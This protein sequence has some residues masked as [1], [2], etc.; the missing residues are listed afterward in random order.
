[1]HETVS[2]PLLRRA[3]AITGVKLRYRNHLEIINGIIDKYYV[4]HKL[5]KEDPMRLKA[6]VNQHVKIDYDNKVW[7]LIKY[8]IVAKHDFTCKE[9]E[10][11]Y[12]EEYHEAPDL[13]PLQI[14]FFRYKHPYMYVRKKQKI[15]WKPFIDNC[16]R[17]KGTDE[18]TLHAA[19]EWL[20]RKGFKPYSN[21]H[22][23]FDILKVQGLVIRET[24]S[25][26]VS[27]PGQSDVPPDGVSEPSRVVS[28]DAQ[29]DDG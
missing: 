1:M 12:D 26:A 3:L 13:D 14:P 18:N 23:E 16:V 11:A 2:P 27:A 10:Q 22:P 20:Y 21:C 25:S 9:Y 29:P 24:Q 6:I 15:F 5:G 17:G 28:V 4:K 8:D 7:D 19:N